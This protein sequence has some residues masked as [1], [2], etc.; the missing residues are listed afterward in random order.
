MTV[1]V[2]GAGA[3]KHA[4]YP[5]AYSI[6]KDLLAWMKS[7]NASIFEY[8]LVAEQIREIFGQLEDVDDFFEHVTQLVK[9]HQ[10]GTVEQR[11]LKAIAANQ[12]Y[13]AIEAIRDWFLE[14]RGCGQDDAYADFAA[15]IIQPGDCILTFNYDVSLD[16]RLNEFGKWHIGNGYGFTVAGFPANSPTKL[17]KLHGS[18]NWLALMDGLPRGGAALVS[19]VFASPRPAIGTRELEF[20]GYPNS[21]DEIFVGNQPALPLMIVGR[22]KDFSFDTSMGL[23]YVQFWEGLWQQAKVALTNAARVVICGYSLPATDK[24]ACNLLMN[25]PR[26]DA[27]IL[28]L[29]G[30]G[31]TEEIVSLYKQKDFKN[32]RPANEI[33]FEDWVSEFSTAMT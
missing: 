2:I 13:A 9:K 30:K 11:M 22:S 1:Y 7:C 21:Q 26:K 15:K 14:I 5:L 12:R 28:V 18:T 16:R 17:F 29:S 24:A 19:C 4:G 33:H 32:V 31:R 8:P 25:F 3:S 27:E 23:E 20:L 6:G 10:S